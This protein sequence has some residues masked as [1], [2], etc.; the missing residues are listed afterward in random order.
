MHGH[1]GERKENLFMLAKYL[2]L[3]VQVLYLTEHGFYDMHTDVW[4]TSF[5]SKM[6]IYTFLLGFFS[7]S[8]KKE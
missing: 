4:L 8:Y 3:A 1:R 2:I 7:P 5:S 6:V